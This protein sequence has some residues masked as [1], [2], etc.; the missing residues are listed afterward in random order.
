VNVLGPACGRRLLYIRK[1][2]SHRPTPLI[3][4]RRGIVASSRDNLA[5]HV[6]IQALDKRLSV[7]GK[8]L[9][10]C[11]CRRN[12]PLQARHDSAVSFT[13]FYFKGNRRAKNF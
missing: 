3:L 12:Q 8:P 5:A 1:S 9:G 2:F 4:G 10:F 7:L 6:R 11:V 13:G